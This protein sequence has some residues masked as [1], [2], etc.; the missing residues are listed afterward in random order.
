MFKICTKTFVEEDFCSKCGRYSPR[1]VIYCCD[2]NG[3][4]LGQY[5]WKTKK[6]ICGRISEN[7][8]WNKMIRSKLLQEN[9]INL[10]INF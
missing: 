8:F 6:C 9:R 2:N 3:N 4:K 7:R 10:L 5:D 1:E